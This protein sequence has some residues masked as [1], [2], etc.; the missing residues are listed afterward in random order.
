MSQCLYEWHDGWSPEHRCRR[1]DGHPGDHQCQCD[2]FVSRWVAEHGDEALAE[3]AEEARQ[4]LR[5]ELQALQSEE[6]A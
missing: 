6:L 4:R 1:L 2:A 5:K 3:S